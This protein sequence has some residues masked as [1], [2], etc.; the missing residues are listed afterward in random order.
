[1]TI[2]NCGVGQNFLIS[3]ANFLLWTT[4]LLLGVKYKI[5]AYRIHSAVCELN[6]ANRKFTRE[7]ALR[8]GGL[9][10][11]AFVFYI[12]YIIIMPLVLKG[13]LPQYLYIIASI[14]SLLF[15][16]AL[17]IAFLDS[18]IQLK[19]TLQETTSSQVSNRVQ[20]A[21]VV[22]ISLLAIVQMIMAF[23]YYYNLSDIFM[24]LDLVCL[25]AR[26]LVVVCLAYQTQR[27]SMSIVISSHVDVHGDVVVS[28]IC[29]QTQ[30]ELFAVTIK[31]TKLNFS[32][33]LEDNDNNVNASLI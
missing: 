33:K 6:V 27:F 2:T 23:F 5:T 12:L 10:A 13:E 19:E 22:M 28:G 25:F 32:Q 18:F 31:Q 7:I 14:L 17:T 24:L 21:L 20:I 9:L 1:M 26:I 15:I 11:S 16:I 29:V 8:Y 30:E 3:T 4:S